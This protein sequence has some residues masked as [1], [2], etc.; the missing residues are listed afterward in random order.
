MTWEHYTQNWRD[1]KR[2]LK[3]ASALEILALPAQAMLDSIKTRVF[4]HGATTDGQLMEAYS[5]KPAS[6]SRSEFD[7]KSAFK[8]GRGK[9]MY[10]PQGYRQ[11]REIQ[12]K[13]VSYINL[14]Y[15]G[16]FKDSYKVQTSGNTARLLLTTRRGGS[17]RFMHEQRFGPILSA[18]ETERTAL[19]EAIKVSVDKK[20]IET[21]T[22]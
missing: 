9:S 19:T 18:N 2:D 20:T 16:K 8:A 7:D 21:L 13:Q 14:D 22:A 12:G 1:L 10:L 5:T 11:L 3:D 17:L 15:T 6:F 4:E